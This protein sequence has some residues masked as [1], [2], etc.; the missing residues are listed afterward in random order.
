MPLDTVKTQLRK[1]LEHL[2]N[3]MAQDFLE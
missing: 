3:E 2:R 1:G